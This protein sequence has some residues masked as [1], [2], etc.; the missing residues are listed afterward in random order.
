MII[1]LYSMTTR[2]WQIFY[3]ISTWGDWIHP[4]EI[5]VFLYQFLPMKSFE[6]YRLIRVAEIPHPYYY[7]VV[8]SIWSQSCPRRNYGGE[9][10]KSREFSFILYKLLER[11]S[12]FMGWGAGKAQTRKNPETE[13]KIPG[14]GLS[15]KPYTSSISLTFRFTNIYI[16]IWNEGYNILSTIWITPCM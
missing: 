13:S 8:Q 9:W 15:L 6:S 1:R 10:Q 11:K 5:P 4:S 14:H 16:F 2:F 7:S 3:S 12:P